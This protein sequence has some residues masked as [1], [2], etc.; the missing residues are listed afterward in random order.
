MAPDDSV[1]FYG[2]VIEVDTLRENGR[3][4]DMFAYV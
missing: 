2:I 4:P 3:V 1:N